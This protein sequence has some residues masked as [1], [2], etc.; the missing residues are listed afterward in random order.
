MSLTLTLCSF[1]QIE[2]VGVFSQISNISF[3]SY[4]QDQ[5]PQKRSILDCVTIIDVLSL[6]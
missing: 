1:V 3:K 2:S 4:M 5:Q 6:V